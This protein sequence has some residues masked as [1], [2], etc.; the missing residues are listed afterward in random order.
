MVAIRIIIGTCY[1]QLQE[2][3]WKKT[4]PPYMGVSGCAGAGGKERGVPIH[5]PFFFVGQAGLSGGRGAPYAGIRSFRTLPAHEIPPT[6]SAGP[7][8]ALGPGRAAKAAHELMPGLVLAGAFLSTL[9][10]FADFVRS[11]SR[12]RQ[13]TC[14]LRELCHSQDPGTCWA[15]GVG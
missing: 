3:V 7:A 4:G 8:S 14:C 11:V 5:G 9:I 2:T 12:S 15:N 1:V 10:R 13:R 6:R